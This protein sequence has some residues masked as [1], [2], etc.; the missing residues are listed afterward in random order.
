MTPRRSTLSVPGHVAKM[1]AKALNSAAD[2]V[3][4]DL[5]DSVPPDAKEKAR[6]QV[7]ETLQSR[8]ARQRPLA[9]RIN[10]L[11]TPYGYRDL[12]E[13]AEAAGP[14]IDTVVVPKVNCAGDIHFVDRLLNGIAWH[15]RQDHAVGIEASIETA[16]GLNDVQAIAASSTRLKTL[17][18]GIADY[19]ASVGARLVSLS[20][21]GEKEEAIYPGHRWHHALSRIVMAAKAN[22]LMAIDAPYGNF[23]DTAGLE[24]AAGLAGAIGC[25]GKWA[26]HPLQIETINTVFT[27]SAED[28]DRARRIIDAD[29][30]ARTGGRGAVAVDGRMVDQ[31]TVRLARRL[32]AQAQHLGLL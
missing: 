7:I 29:E 14:R 1:H 25:D 28:I 21:H 30:A 9:V 24:Y 5:E 16:E 18:F 31:A 4:L 27:P 23:K 12:L 22:G 8:E 11:D 17:V 6:R 2:I 19:A 13:V 26:I 20:G 10:A 3:M 32:W 15:H